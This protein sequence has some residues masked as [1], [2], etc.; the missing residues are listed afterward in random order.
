MQKTFYLGIDP[1]KSGAWAIIE[2]V[3]EVHSV[4]LYEDRAAIDKELPIKLACLEKVHAMPGQGTVSMFTFGETFGIWQGILE[5]LHIPFEMVTPGKWQ[6]SI[7]DFLP[8]KAL[9]VAD[10]DKGQN[11]KRRAENRNAL[12]SAVTAY[13]IRRYPDLTK[14]LSIK[15]NQ[16]IADALCLALYARL[17]EGK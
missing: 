13:V 15:K 11:A 10:E 8:A 2:D 4:G 14:T 17:R 16:G 9:K 6:K 1:G 3:G 7:L 12:K 5:A